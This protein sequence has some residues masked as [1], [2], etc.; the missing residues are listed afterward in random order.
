MS[1]LQNINGSLY[2]MDA[3]DLVQL[4]AV[5]T[6][7][8][9]GGTPGA[10][11]N[12]QT[13]VDQLAADDVQAQSDIGTLQ[14]DKAEAFTIAVIES[15]STS[16]AAYSAGDYIYHANALYRVTAPIS[17]G[18]TFTVGT[19]IET[20]TVCDEISD[21]KTDLSDLEDDMSEYHVVPSRNLCPFYTNVVGGFTYTP[22]ENGYTS[23]S[24]ASDTRSWSYSGSNIL[25]RLPAGSYHFHVFAKTAYTAGYTGARVYD[26]ANN[27][28]G[29][30]ANFDGDM[31]FDFTL[32]ATTDL[33]LIYKLGNG[34]YAF[35]VSTAADYAADP[36]YVPHWETLKDSVAELTER[37]TEHTDEP[38]LIAAAAA[39]QT[40]AAQMEYLLPKYNAL[41]SAQKARTFLA[42]N[43]YTGGRYDNFG[44]NSCVFS[45]ITQGSDATVYFDSYR[46]DTKKC[47]RVAISTSGAVSRSDRSNESNSYGLQLYYV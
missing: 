16:S 31:G 34:S 8:I 18:D 43:T 41:T 39:N 12:G 26:S 4:A 24:S 46:L 33:G 3:S 20:A 40:L 32:A 10:T 45:A 37:L 2:R 19:N 7:G 22:D 21:I 35:M 44:V 5:D 15:A 27:L 13:L 30:L 14:S 1:V 9:L 29:G 6:E 23:C 38:I 42:Y 17:I 28:I 25:F 11:T 36:S 47:I